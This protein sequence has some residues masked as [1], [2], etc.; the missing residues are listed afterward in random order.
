MFAMTDVSAFNR[1]TLP[2]PFIK[3]QKRFSDRQLKTDEKIYRDTKKVRE[4]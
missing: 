2:L 4:T 3:W 1:F